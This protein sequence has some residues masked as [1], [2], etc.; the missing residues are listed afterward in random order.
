MSKSEIVIAEN[1]KGRPLNRITAPNEDALSVSRGKI[2]PESKFIRFAGVKH[3]PWGVLVGI[4]EKT[5][6]IS[7]RQAHEL[8]ISILRCA[9]DCDLG[10]L[11]VL[12][13]NGERNLL[14]PKQAQN[15]AKGLLRRADAADDFQLQHNLKVVR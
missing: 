12:T 11:V 4:N 1:L 2:T 9:R 7:T 13:A 6:S 10:E 5:G 8:G 15:F 3:Q 14:S